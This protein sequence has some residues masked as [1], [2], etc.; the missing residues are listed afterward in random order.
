MPIET[1]DHI[2]MAAAQLQHSTDAD[3]KR[4][5]GQM[6]YRLA[7]ILKQLDESKAEASG[8]SRFA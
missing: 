4:E 5:I 8:G 6:L 2:M 7:A 1:L 3:A